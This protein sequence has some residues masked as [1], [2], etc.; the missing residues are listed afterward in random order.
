M[1]SESSVGKSRGN[2]ETDS[3]AQKLA[4][5]TPNIANQSQHP[6]LPVFDKNFG[7]IL[8][9]RRYRPAVARDH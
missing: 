6:S 2:M 3:L 4:A 1:G 7:R 5:A 8:L 9:V